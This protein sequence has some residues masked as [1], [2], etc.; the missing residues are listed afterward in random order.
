M[1]SAAEN[2][3]PRSLRKQLG[4]GRKKK[5]S[6]NVNIQVLNCS[7]YTCRIAPPYHKKGFLHIRSR[8]F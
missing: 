7:V 1:K 4:A 8:R 5:L 6:L 2:E 3:A